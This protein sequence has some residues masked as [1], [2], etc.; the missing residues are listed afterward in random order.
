MKI[1]T[2]NGER[3]FKHQ[4]NSSDRSL[5]ISKWLWCSGFAKQEDKNFKKLI[6]LR[7]RLAATLSHD[8]TLGMVSES[9]HMNGLLILL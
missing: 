5:K 6:T 4:S 2:H 1:Y 3:T 9:S 7:N 8:K